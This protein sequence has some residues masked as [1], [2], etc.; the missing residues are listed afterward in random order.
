VPKIDPQALLLPRPAVGR[1]LYTI[2]IHQ[3]SLPPTTRLVLLVIAWSARKDG[4]GSYLSLAAISS[5]TGLSRRHAQRI[6]ASSKQLGW[7]EVQTR[8]G[9]ANDWLLAAPDAVHRGCHPRQGGVTPTSGGGDMGVTRRKNLGRT[10]EVRA[11]VAR[12]PWCGVCAEDTRLRDDPDGG[13]M[14]RCPECHPLR[15]PL[16]GPAKPPKSAL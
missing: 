9:R 6:I 13:P 10:Q 1:S 15:K 3:S 2:L 8:S 11:R 16:R 4:T 5:R 12:Q 7:L 14:R